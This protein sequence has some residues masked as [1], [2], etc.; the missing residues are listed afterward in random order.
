MSTCDSARWASG[1]IIES[2]DATAAKSCRALY[3][4]AQ[5]SVET[6]SDSERAGPCEERR[7]RAQRSEPISEERRERAQRSEPRDR[8]EPAKRLARE[9]VGGSAGAKPPGVSD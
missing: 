8:S 3:N 4:Q 9:R 6:V 5:S 1:P 2:F 7:E